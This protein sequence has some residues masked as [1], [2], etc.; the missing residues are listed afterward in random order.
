MD[1]DS[2]AQHVANLERELR[3][4]RERLARTERERDEYQSQVHSLNE[5]GDRMTSAASSAAGTAEAALRR[6]LRAKPVLEAAEKLVDGYVRAHKNGAEFDQEGGRLCKV[7]IDA[8][9][10]YRKSAPS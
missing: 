6:L 1:V 2:P 5:R 10:E 9:I 3:V 4:T 8:V 7:L